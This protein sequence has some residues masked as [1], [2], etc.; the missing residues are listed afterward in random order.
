[1]RVVAGGLQL[2]KT[3]VPS[4]RVGRRSRVDRQWNATLAEPRAKARLVR[5]RAANTWAKVKVWLLLA[6]LKTASAQT[7]KE[8]P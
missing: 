6:E 4:V 5:A 8:A 2:V 3:E 7:R 1:V